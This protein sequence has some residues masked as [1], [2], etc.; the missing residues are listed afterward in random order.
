MEAAL[1]KIGDG[2]I[3]SLF[4]Q[5]KEEIVCPQFWEIKPF[6]G[7]RFDCQWC[8]DGNTLIMMSDLSWKQ[9]NQLKVGDLVMGFERN[10]STRFVST[11]VQAIRKTTKPR[12]KLTTDKTT[13]ICSYEHQF[14]SGHGRWATA[15]H[16]G[17]AEIGIKCLTEPSK[18]TPEDMPYM[19]GYLC[20]VSDG[21]GTMGHYEYETQQDISSYRLAMKDKEAIERATRYFKA[22]GVEMNSFTHKAGSGSQ[23]YAIRKSGKH[24]Y[25]KILEIFKSYE[26]FSNYHIGYIAGIFD[27]EGSFSASNLR[28]SNTN[29]SILQRAKKALSKIGLKG[30]I[31]S[32]PPHCPTLRVSGGI[33]E[34]V[35]FFNITNPAIKRKWPKD[36]T[37]SFNVTSPVQKAERLE[38][39]ELIDI[40]TG[41]E[42]FIAN[43][44]ASHNCYL[45]GTYR[46]KKNEVGT[47]VGKAP[48]FK[49]AI[50]TRKHVLSAMKDISTPTMF[51]CGEVSDGLL[52]PH[53]LDSII[54]PAFKE[55]SKKKGHK[56]LL[57]T[58][59]TDIGFLYKAKAQDCVVCAFS[60]NAE[61]VSGTWEVGAPHPWER[62]SAA[63]KVSDWGYPVR[64]RIDP[65]VPVEDW[66]HGYRQLL[67]KIMEYVPNTEVIT[68]GSLR[69]T[70]TNLRT[71]Q[72][73]QNDTSYTSYLTER[74]TRDIRAPESLRV[75]MYSFIINELRKRGYKGHVA[76]CKETKSLWKKMMEVKTVNGVQILPFLP[77]PKDM[78]CNCTLAKQ[79]KDPNAKM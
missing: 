31:E 56:L 41:T 43:G 70:P 53:I 28:I 76:I 68:I 73:L 5:T 77:N 52:F 34:Y 39:G 74:N 44:L 62:L 3:V 19:A 9:L 27:A 57:L 50:K 15:K 20:G 33:K 36:F 51:N 8:L 25:D 37:A 30:Y 71:C 60:V 14:L 38:P 16:L 63:K 48:T 29:I 46:F 66:Q 49:D 65:M 4:N 26:R 40:Q 7:C 69:M 17:T 32:F 1:T 11:T 67:D 22:F 78:V 35:R 54:I 10:G 2:T 72:S 18:R 58:K 21:D 79:D 42:N 55:A 64:L 6:N 13:I 45:N 12:L 61:W 24:N 75:E 59:S 47:I 23:L